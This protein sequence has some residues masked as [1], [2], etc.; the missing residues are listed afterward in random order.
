MHYRELLIKDE[1]VS[2]LVVID[3]QIRIGSAEVRM[4]GIGDVETKEK[5]RKKGYMR[6]LMEDAV[7]YIKNEGYDVSMLFGI[8]NFYTKFGYAVC[9]PEY[10][11]TLSTRDAEDAKNNAENYKIRKI[12]KKDIDSVFGLYDENNQ[13]RVCSLIRTKKYFSGFPRGSRDEQQ[14]DA[15]LVKDSNKEFVAYAAF[16][17]SKEEVNIVEV[18]SIADRAYPA[19]LYEFAKMAVKRRC[20]HITLFMPPDHPFAEFCS[21]YGSQLTAQYPKNGGGV[22]RMINQ[23]TLFEKIKKE[24]ERRISGSKFKACSDSLEIRTDM[25]NITLKICDGTLNIYSEEKV[26]NFLTLSQ[27][28]LIQLIVGY[29]S[30]RDILNDSEVEIGGDIEP[31]L[32]VLFPK[33]SPYVWLADHF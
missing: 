8:P 22:M 10:K 21:R 27:A 31:L 13:N 5:H 4:G 7:E 24:L 32:G 12:R 11:L 29:R 26:E 25:E 6:R 30:V 15:F 33:T 1:V 16:D 28:K 18:E 2:S 9:L 3:Y 19:L 20:G 23:K 14:A 17:K